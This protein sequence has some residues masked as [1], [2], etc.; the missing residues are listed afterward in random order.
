MNPK[1][2]NMPRQWIKS[3]T[4]PE[5]AAPRRLP[6]MVAV[7]S[8]PIITWRC[9]S[10]TKSEMSAMPT[11]KLPP[12]AAP[13]RMRSTNSS[14]KSVT[15][16]DRNDD[17][18]SRAKARDHHPRLA[19]G[20]RHRAENRL[21]Q[22]V[23]REGRRQ[24]RHGRRRDGEIRRDLRHHRIDGANAQRRTEDQEADDVERSVHVGDLAGAAVART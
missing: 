13:A 1:I 15:M 3:A 12:Q 21:C 8:R 16:A 4:M 24:Q 20:V 2:T 5:A 10:G 19:E 18:V 11:G 17:T 6:E 9:A 14:Q 23:G 7:S 22:P